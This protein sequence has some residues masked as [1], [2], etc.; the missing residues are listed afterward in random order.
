MSELD[1]LWQEIRALRRRVAELE[2]LE[3]VGYA[4]ECGDADTVDS[5]HADTDGADAHVIATDATGG[6]QIDGDLTLLSL[7]QFLGTGG[8]AQFVY[9]PPKQVT[10]ST[11]TPVFKITTNN[12]AGNA[13]AG[14]YSVWV[15]AHAT[16]GNNA[17]GSNMASMFA[18]Y[19]WTRAQRHDGAGVTGF[20]AEIYQTASAATNAAARDISGIALTTSE[21]SEYV[22]NV[23]FNVGLTGSDVVKPWLSCLVLLMWSTYTTPP[24][25]AAL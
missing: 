13:D 18:Q 1:G 11:A 4:S 22:V 12:E 23:E 19:M 9:I 15:L 3:R 25:I 10:D 5:Y 17:T 16:H 24:V 8:G 6:A 14:S 7:L 2:A 20:E 21:V